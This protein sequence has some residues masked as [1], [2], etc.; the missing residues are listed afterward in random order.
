MNGYYHGLYIAASFVAALIAVAGIVSDS[1]IVYGI[2]PGIIGGTMFVVATVRFFRS[3]TD[4]AGFVANLCGFIY[5]QAYQAN[6]V[7]LPNFTGYLIPIPKPDQVIGIA[8]SNLTVAMLLGAYRAVSGPM[9]GLIGGLVP[10]PED[11]TRAKVDRGLV[12]GFWILFVLVAIPNVLFGKVVF[13]AYRSIMYQRLAWSH[14]DEFAGFDV[15]G[16]PVGSSVVNMALWASSL[17]FLWLYLL[18]SRHRVLMYVLSPLVVLWTASVVMQGTRT[19]LVTMAIATGVYLFGDS[20]AS[21][22]LLLHALW[23]V[24]LLFVALQ[25]ASF[26]RAEGLA[27]VDV[28]DLSSRLLEVTGNEGASSQ[29]D[30]IEYFRT[31]VAGRG[32]A[33]NPALGFVRGV[34]E[35]PIEGLLMPIPRALFPL[36]PVDPT[37]EEFNLFYENVRLG[38]NTSEVVMGCSPGLI[39]RELIKYGYLGPVTLLFWL[40]LIL[41]LADR[42][43]AAG[44]ASDFHRIFAAPLIAFFVA[45]ARDWAQVWFIPFLPAL[46]IFILQARNAKL[47]RLAVAASRRQPT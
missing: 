3:K 36:K 46:L 31:E 2:V 41:G 17:Y 11:V 15:W 7:M 39:G 1:P 47:A 21:A 25:I 30:G 10:A 14:E 20:K 18:K 34:V 12:F 9:G 6:P 4:L 42:L 38:M 32:V 13:G 22:K 23:A 16:G 26:Y 28:S 43:Y 19:Y 33:P 37:G 35:R 27:A 44:S 8:L 45:Q 29:M 40:G 5:Y 24:P